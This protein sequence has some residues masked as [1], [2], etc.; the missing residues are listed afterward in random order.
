MFLSRS[1]TPPVRLAWRTNTAAELFLG[2]F[3]LEKHIAFSGSLLC[4]DALAPILSPNPTGP[5][6]VR[7]LS[8]PAH[9]E[10]HHPPRVR[11]CQFWHGVLFAR[12][13]QSHL[14]A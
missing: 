9:T 7:S 10:S 2:G 5:C 12:Y 14:R 13:R 1:L 4:C 11:S 8:S 6:A 3:A